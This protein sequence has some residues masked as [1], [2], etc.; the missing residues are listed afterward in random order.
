MLNDINN[1]KANQKLIISFWFFDLKKLMRWCIFFKYLFW[2]GGG[3][4][5]CLDHS[6]RE[7]V[8]L[9]YLPKTTYYTAFAFKL[10][11]MHE[12]FIKCGFVIIM[13]RACNWE[14]WIQSCGFFFKGLKKWR[15]EE[16]KLRINLA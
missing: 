4:I 5:A 7:N 9:Q 2:W 13:Q 15:R 6:L 10:V 3:K 12:E 16:H 11:F 8:C 14:G 1:Y